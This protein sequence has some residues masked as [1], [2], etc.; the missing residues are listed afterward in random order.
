M[1]N[2]AHD[3][4]VDITTQSL[5]K[6]EWSFTVNDT[7]KTGSSTAKDTYNWLQNVTYLYFKYIKGNV[8]DVYGRLAD[9]RGVNY[10]PRRINTVTEAV[11]QM[12]RRIQNHSLYNSQLINRLDG[13][14]Y[15]LGRDGKLAH[16][17]T[18]TQK[19]SGNRAPTITGEIFTYTNTGADSWLNY[20]EVFW[21]KVPKT[22]SYVKQ[23]VK[24]TFP[25]FTVKAKPKPVLT[26]IGNRSIQ[27]GKTLSF[28]VSA[29]KGKE[30][31]TFTVKSGK[32]SITGTTYSYTPVDADV[33]NQSVTIQVSDK[34]GKKDSETFTVSVSARPVVVHPKPTFTA[35]GNKSVQV[36]KT[37]SFGLSAS[38]GTIPY[39]FSVTSGV[40]SI[41]G[42]GFDT[43]SYTPL[44]SAVGSQTSTIQVSDKNNQTASET[45]TITVTA[46]PVTPD[47]EEEE[48]EEAEDE[49]QKVIDLT[50]TNTA[51]KQI[52]AQLKM[53]VTNVNQNALLKN[54]LTQLEKKPDTTTLNQILA[55]LK[56]KKV[57]DTTTQ[58]VLLQNILT[59][60]KKDRGSTTTITSST[61]QNIN[62][63]KQSGA[64]GGRSVYRVITPAQYES[65]GGKFVPKIRYVSVR[66]L[67]TGE[68]AGLAARGYKIEYVAQ[69]TPLSP[70]SPY[71]PSVLERVE[72]TVTKLPEG[73]KE[74]GHRRSGLSILSNDRTTKS[75]IRRNMLKRGRASTTRRS[76]F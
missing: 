24:I 67:T 36:G 71:A 40:G 37:L 59:E 73:V 16:V 21:A 62:Q 17:K 34:N 10:D 33:G 27:V 65:K 49:T 6:G 47:P 53:P 20:F 4:S 38:G 70:S 42:V 66:R 61:T 57:Q 52:L 45:I 1:S 11:N 5:I 7:V 44:S 43:F 50:A 2:G 64:G 19:L 22:T 76:V 55:E 15:T 41:V 51:L 58:D 3:I 74:L 63:A 54:I 30:P 9:I 32:G 48:E 12:T 72:G 26:T 68:V 18:V 56:K 28:T 13:N 60:L 23:T 46:V 69:D 35:I 31:Y 8:Y 25:S 75:V 39:T 29:S 14:L